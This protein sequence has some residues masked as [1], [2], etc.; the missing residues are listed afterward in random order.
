MS[1]HFR[2]REMRRQVSHQF[3]TQR[4]TWGPFVF[5]F[6]IFIIC[7]FLKYL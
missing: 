5:S 4:Q 7:V 2:H 3:N 6:S 1:I